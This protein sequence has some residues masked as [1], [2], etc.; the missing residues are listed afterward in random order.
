MAA[1]RSILR[2]SAAPEGDRHSGRG[3]RRASVRRCD[4]RPPRRA[5]ATCGPEGG[6]QG[7]VQLRSSAAPEGDRHH[8]GPYRRDGDVGVA[9]LGRP[10]GRPPPR[11]TGR[12]SEAPVVAILG[13]PGGRPPPYD[14]RAGRRGRECCDPRPPRRATATFALGLGLPLLTGLRSSAAPE[15]DR[16]HEPGGPADHDRAVAI[17]GRPGGRPPL[18]GRGAH[19][20]GAGVAI[21]GRPGGRPPLRRPPG[22]PPLLDRLRSSAA[23]EGDRHVAWRRLLAPR[24]MLRSSAAPEG[25][26]HADVQVYGATCHSVAILGRP[27]GRPPRSRRDRAH[28]RTPVAIL[29]RPGGRPPPAPLRGDRTGCAGCDPRP[30]RRATATRATTT[31]VRS[32]ARLRSSAAPEGD[33]H[34]DPGRREDCRVVVAILGRPGGRPPRC[35]PVPRPVPPVVAI[36][37]RPGGRPPPG[38]RR[39]VGRWWTGCDPRPPRRATAT[40]ADQRVHLRPTQ[41]YPVNA[42]ANERLWTFSFGVTCVSR[43][44]LGFRTCARPSIRDQARNEWLLMMQHQ[45]ALSLLYLTFPLTVSG[46]V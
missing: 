39:T 38:R 46:L 19:H 20:R 28:H 4:P 45:Q 27:G 13:R 10:G 34:C 24:G 9:I 16:H 1:Q 7:H 35:G 8:C 44:C 14:L 6:A 2:A 41:A 5:T 37:G 12:P 31:R 30:P 26:R 42:K 29:G 17:L 43:V 33:R 32:T 15:G 22:R 11:L 3:M 25:D 18:R 40:L 23:P 21:L 36:L